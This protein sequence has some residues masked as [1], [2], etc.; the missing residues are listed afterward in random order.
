[1]DSKAVEGRMRRILLIAF[2]ISLVLLTL[3]SKTIQSFTLPAVVT[4]APETGQLK[5]TIEG[6][7]KLRPADQ[8]EVKNEKGLELARLAVKEGSRVNKGDIIAEYNNGTLERQIRDAE[9]QLQKSKI[10]ADKLKEQ[11]IQARIA[12]DE[13]QIREA[14]RAIELDRIEQ[15]IQSQQLADLRED[16]SNHRYERAPFGGIITEVKASVEDATSP[17][18]TIAVLMREKDGYEF[19]FTLPEHEAKWLEE[20]ESVDV[21]L[22]G[23]TGHRLNGAI[24][25]IDIGDPQ[26]PSTGTSVPGS[27]NSAG[28][29]A[30]GS[31]A[32]V[33]IRIPAAA[34][35][36]KPESGMRAKISIEK[37]SEQTGFLIQSK[38]LKQDMDGTYLFLVKETL[39]AFGNEYIVYKAAVN[40][41][42][43]SGEQS[44]VQ[45]LTSK[46]NIIT[47]TSEPLKEGNRVRVK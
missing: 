38:W 43:D 34:E 35:G 30:A 19:S 41:L 13:L 47:E 24:H 45:G 44:L 6:E 22:T 39:G 26:A 31:A 4:T 7:G 5:M 1:M 28:E 36:I 9:A 15:Q 8:I 27:D 3:F 11:F 32:T 42:A 14:E 20:G 18:Q 37:K 25:S 2:V 16:L 23:K 33:T 12:G 17:G 46:D 40:V 21:Q 29:S 10:N